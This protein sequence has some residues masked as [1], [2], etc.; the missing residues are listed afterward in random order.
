MAFVNE[1][2]VVNIGSAN[3][4]LLPYDVTHR[5]PI[6]DAITSGSGGGHVFGGNESLQPMGNSTSGH[7]AQD[8]EDFLAIIGISLMFCVIGV[9][10]IVGNT[11]IILFIL[12]DKKMRHSVTNLFIMNLA[13]SDMLIMLFGVP[14][15]VQ[16]MLNRGW[17]LGEIMCKTE[18]YVLVLSLYSSVITAVAVC[19]E[20]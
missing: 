13:I 9:V 4:P 6:G 3:Q 16:F 17:L 19:V 18:R 7:V 14:E 15:T 2:L 1:T 5:Q 20:R 11:L 12:L 10:G 8:D